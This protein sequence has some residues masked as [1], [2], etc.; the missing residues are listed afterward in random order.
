MLI[1]AY[2]ATGAH[3]ETTSRRATLLDLPLGDTASELPT[4]FKSFA[5]GS[6]GGPPAMPI[7]GWSDFARC[8]RDG[9]GLHE[10]AVEYDDAGERAARAAGNPAAAWGLGTSIDYFPIVASALF[11][12]AGTLQG[13]RLV[14]D[15]RP[16]QQKMPFLLYRPYGEHYLLQ[17]YLMDRFGMSAA[18]CRELPLKP[19]QSPVFGMVA[20]RVCDRTDVAGRRHYHIETR[21]Y[22]RRGEHDIDPDTGR[23]AERH[24]LSETRAEIRT[25]GG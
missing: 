3:A 15:P 17:L 9:E 25:T 19:G 23:P 10:V 21:F 6:D 20:N 8:P 24:F 22:R 5:C 7:A 11:D 14:T 1:C 13:V 2:V 18:D 12:S 4:G 16:D